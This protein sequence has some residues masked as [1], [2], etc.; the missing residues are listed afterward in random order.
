MLT[1]TQLLD[2]NLSDEEISKVFYRGEWA[3]LEILK[4]NAKFKGYKEEIWPELSKNAEFFAIPWYPLIISLLILAVN[5]SFNLFDGSVSIFVVVL[6]LLYIYYASPLLARLKEKNR[7]KLLDGVL[8]DSPYHQDK[9]KKEE[10]EIP[11][12]I[13]ED[14]KKDFNTKK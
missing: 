6:S 5:L 7:I 12:I 10:P 14:E 11:V 2:P 4:R 8:L 1:E 13:L 9:Y 3:E